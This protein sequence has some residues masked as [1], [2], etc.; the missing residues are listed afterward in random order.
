M[1]LGAARPA[2]QPDLAVLSPQSSPLKNDIGEQNNAGASNPSH[3]AGGSQ[4]VDVV[5][6]KNPL[7]AGAGGLT[8]RS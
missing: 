8:L 2:V 5:L 1:I 3:T 6:P 4:A 7:T